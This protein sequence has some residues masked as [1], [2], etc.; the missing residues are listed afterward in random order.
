MDIRKLEQVYKKWF[1][2]EDFDPIQVEL[3]TVLS[4]KIAGDPVWCFI[5]GASGGLKTESLRAFTKCDIVFSISTLTKNALIGGHTK[6]DKY[7][8][9]SKLD[10]K[11]LIVK[12]F[13]AI[14]EKNTYDRN[15]IFGQLRDCYDGYSGK[16]FA[17][18]GTKSQV[19]HFSLLAGVTP[20]IDQYH[21]LTQELG[22][23]FLKIRLDIE[24]REEETKKA[25]R[26][27]G[28]E[29]IMREEISTAV[30][31]FIEEKIQKVKMLHIPLK[32]QAQLDKIADFVAKGRTVVQRD[33]FKKELLYL[34]SPEHPTRLVKQLS[35]LM[36][37]LAITR[38]KKSV[39]KKE[40]Q[41][42]S[43]VAL[44]SI[45]AVRFKVLD[46]IHSP[47][48]TNEI[49]RD[50]NLPLA[51]VRIELENLRILR[52]VDL[53]D[54]HAQD[55]RGYTWELSESAEEILGAYGTVKKR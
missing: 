33:R 41:T 8:L 5:V 10:G 24:S 28:K 1:Y 51:T 18:V 14:L 44:N 39:S 40:L 23:R 20:V 19:A 46:S 21:I 15:E 36:S 25:R 45:P 17:S 53:I 55:S 16:A 42:V 52:L 2:L 48:Q 38:G 29:D 34:P 43:R 47:V 32:L 13:S 50:T 3:S 6:S 54:T 9:L 49:V 31:E 26:N 12:D 37:C 11:C 7:D 30:K 35:K 4:T 27:T 22:E